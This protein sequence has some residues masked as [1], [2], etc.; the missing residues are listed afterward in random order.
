MSLSKEQIYKEIN[1]ILYEDWDPIDINEGG[2]IDEYEGYVPTIFSLKSS[3]ASAEVIAS[4]LNKIIIEQM[5]LA[6][7]FE[8]CREIAKKILEVN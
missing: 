5:G 3:G 6:G 2:P 1:K 8:H 4:E 7:N